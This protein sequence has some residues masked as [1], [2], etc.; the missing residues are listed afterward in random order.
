MLKYVPYVV[1]GLYNGYFSV[2]V[3]FVVLLVFVCVMNI[4]INFLCPYCLFL[5]FYVY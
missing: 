2:V 4:R 3:A 5:S 1:K